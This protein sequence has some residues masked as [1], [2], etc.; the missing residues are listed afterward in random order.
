MMHKTDKNEI[1]FSFFLFRLH[2]P[3]RSLSPFSLLPS[4]FLTF[5]SP[6]LHRSYR[7]H[8]DNGAKWRVGAWLNQLIIKSAMFGGYSRV[9]LCSFPLV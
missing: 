9:L 8:S 7:G 6:G 4:P 3:A 2:F 1:F 5:S